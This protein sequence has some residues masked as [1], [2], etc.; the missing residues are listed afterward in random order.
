MNSLLPFSRRNAIFLSKYYMETN[1]KG[2]R[3]SSCSERLVTYSKS[4]RWK[5]KD[6]AEPTQHGIID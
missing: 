2:H 3:V 4:D 1:S 6:I 5:F